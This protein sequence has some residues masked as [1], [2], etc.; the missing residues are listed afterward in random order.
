MVVTM[1]NAIFWD[2]R[3]CGSCKNQHFGGIYHLHHQDD[4]NHGAANVS[5]N[6]NIVPS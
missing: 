3:P 2:V 5:S 1:K 4:K 6:Y